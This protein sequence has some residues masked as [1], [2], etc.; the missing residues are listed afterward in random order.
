VFGRLNGLRYVIFRDLKPVAGIS[1]FNS[2]GGKKAGLANILRKFD[3]VV[4]RDIQKL[5]NI[6]DQRKF[7]L[8]GS[9]NGL[10][11]FLPSLL[12]METRLFFSYELIF[13]GYLRK[14]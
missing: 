5:F 1:G 8:A 9:Q 10:D 6:M 4:F 2:I 11:G 13:R 3:S 12:G 7:Y 14:P